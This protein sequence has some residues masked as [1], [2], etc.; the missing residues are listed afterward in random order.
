M[1]HISYIEFRRK[2]ARYLDEAVASR[3]PVV[4][5]RQG[6]KETVHLLS[7]RRNAR[8]LL[9][10]IQ[11]ANAGNVREHA[12]IGRRSTMTATTTDAPRHRRRSRR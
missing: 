6:G 11:Q 3:A 7:S 4:V 5:A 8:R 1:T 2:L 10:S 9:A 12:L